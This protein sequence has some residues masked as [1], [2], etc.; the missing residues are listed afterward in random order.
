[1]AHPFTATAIS[2]VLAGDN[3]PAHDMTFDLAEVIGQKL[4]DFRHYV[5]NVRDPEQADSA[6][7]ELLTALLAEAS[8]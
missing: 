6:V 7:K 5:A 1:M 8:K 4:D 2:T 3:I